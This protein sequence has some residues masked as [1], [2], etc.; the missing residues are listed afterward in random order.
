[1]AGGASIFT[2][3]AAVKPRPSQRSALLKHRA[4]VDWR[5]NQAV[6]FQ[7]SA[8]SEKLLTVGR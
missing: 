6:S 2:R 5:A 8:V 1:M 3:R 4:L 7:L